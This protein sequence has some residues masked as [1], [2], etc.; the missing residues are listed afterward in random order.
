MGFVK[1]LHFQDTNYID[2]LISRQFT[3]KEIRQEP[4]VRKGPKSGTLSDPDRNLR[5]HWSTEV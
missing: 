1:Q 5:D 4:K 3:F 2:G